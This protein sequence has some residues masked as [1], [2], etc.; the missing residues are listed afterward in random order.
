MAIQVES[1]HGT[2]YLSQIVKPDKNSGKSKKEIEAISDGISKLGFNIALPIVCM[3]NEE[4]M[5]QLLTGLPIYEAAVEANINQIWVFLIAAKFQEAEKIL[6]YAELQEKMNEKLI[7][8][9]DWEEF[10]K[11]L[12]DSKS[13]LTSLS[14]IKEG[15]AGLIKQHSPYNSKEAIQKSLGPKRSLNWLKAYKKWIFR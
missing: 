15:Y 12:N 9:D 6:E 7:R 11:F 10:R 1:G 4:D 13:P 5:Y 8:D 3:T 2:I 14:G